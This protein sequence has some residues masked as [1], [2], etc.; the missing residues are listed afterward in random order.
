[1]PKSLAW[2]IT[3]INF[4]LLPKSAIR[5]LYWPF[6]YVW[7]VAM[8][9]LLLDIFF[10]YRFNIVISVNILRSHLFYVTKCYYYYYDIGDKNETFHVE[11]CTAW[12]MTTHTICLCK[13]I[14]WNK[15]VSECILQNREKKQIANFSQNLSWKAA[16]LYCLIAMVWRNKFVCLVKIFIH[17]FKM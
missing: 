17:T 7:P 12:R 5:F 15:H 8:Y 4:F 10:L 6:Y 14:C 3:Q 2:E 13:E 1:M 16:T 9:V 11:T